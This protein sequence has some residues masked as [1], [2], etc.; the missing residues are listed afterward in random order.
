MYSET[1]NENRQEGE[2]VQDAACTLQ[3]L[4]AAFELVVEKTE[5]KGESFNR[6]PPCFFDKVEGVAC[7]SRLNP[8]EQVVNIFGFKFEGEGFDG[9]FE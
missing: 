8:D 5:C 1:G 7:L 2:T 9:I 3:V 6:L 4:V